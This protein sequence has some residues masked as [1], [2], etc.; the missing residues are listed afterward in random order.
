MTLVIT[1]PIKTRGAS[2]ALHRADVIV[3]RITGAE[4]VAQRKRAVWSYTAPLIAMS[5]DQAQPWFAVTHQ[6]SRMDAFFDAMPPGFQLPE[7]A[8]SRYD[9]SAWSSGQP[10]LSSSTPTT[11]T[12]SGL[13]AGQ[14]FL[15]RG[16]YIGV[17]TAKGPELKVVTRTVTSS[18]TGTAVI[19]IEPPF[20]NTPVSVTITDPV[21]RFRLLQPAQYQ[22]APNRI[23]S[24]TLEAIETHD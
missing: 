6:L 20:R 7:Y 19:E 1:P 17:M 2:F 11:L 14:S 16:D 12:V 24:I 23:V 13:D 21:A 10:V 5:Y 8:K 3:S 15:V 18:S 4:V 9:G 22:M